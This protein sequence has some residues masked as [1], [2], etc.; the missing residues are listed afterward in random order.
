MKTLITV[1]IFLLYIIPINSQS[2]YN[3]DLD[4]VRSNDLRELPFDWDKVPASD[5]VCT[6]HGSP[7]DSPDLLHSTGPSVSSGIYGNPYSGLTF[8]SGVRGSN[9]TEDWVFQEG[10]MQEVTGFNVDSV[11]NISFHQSVVKQ[12]H[13]EDSSGSWAV[14]VDTVLIGVSAPS[15]STIPFDE[16]PLVWDERNV[17]FTAFQ[18]T[19][20]IK[21]LPIDDDTL[22]L[23]Y[24]PNGALRM[25]ID[26]ICFDFC[27][28]IVS[29]SEELQESINIYPNPVSDNLFIESKKNYKRINILLFD[30]YGR[31]LINKSF[32]N[33]SLI[34]LDMTKL[35]SGI[36]F[37]Y[38]NIE[39][40]IYSKKILVH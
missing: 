24:E 9:G 14:Y 20:T 19:H 11:Y 5:P 7:G 16:I 21:F 25:G 31:R 3:G 6:A 22:D 15:F 29:I 18:E 28:P 32:S 1:S 40:V 13:I 4:G 38:L 2:F 17:I 33:N 10:I 23:F 34:Q 8:L 26:L 12:K 30:L 27:D 37:V 36:Y 35:Q 39:D